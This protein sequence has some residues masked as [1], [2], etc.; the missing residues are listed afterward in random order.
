MCTG[1]CHPPCI[2]L[3]PRIPLPVHSTHQ[4]RHPPLPCAPHSPL[5]WFPP[6]GLSP[7]WSPYP[8]PR[9]LCLLGNSAPTSHPIQV[10]PCSSYSLFLPLSELSPCWARITAW[11][12]I[13]TM[14]TMSEGHFPPSPLC[15]MVGLCGQGRNQSPH[16]FIIF[17]SQP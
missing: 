17:P 8:E 10:C 15:K 1:L 4:P 5:L 13:V 14:S 6:A 9:S 11:P 7:H 16:L 12:T 3:P 2:P